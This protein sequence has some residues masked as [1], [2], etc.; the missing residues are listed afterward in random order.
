[1][2]TRVQAE[3]EN[4]RDPLILLC[5]DDRYCTLDPST[6]APDSWEKSHSYW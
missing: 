6:P 3:A 1:M 2:I 4:L 5:E